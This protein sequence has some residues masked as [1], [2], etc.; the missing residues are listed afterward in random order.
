MTFDEPVKILSIRQPWASLIVDGHKDIENRTWRSHYRGLVLIHAAK[1][2]QSKGARAFVEKTFGIVPPLDLPRGGIVGM[3]T[4]VDCFEIHSSRW[5]E[6][7]YGWKFTNPQ[8]LPF[9]PEKGMLSFFRP[10][11]ALLEQLRLLP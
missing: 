7:P 2:A 9:I 10:S 6:G 11:V 4:L 1:R 5:F 8:P 3:A